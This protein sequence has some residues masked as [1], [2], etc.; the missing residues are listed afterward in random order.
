MNKTKINEE[1]IV[2][3]RTPQVKA[4]N[5]VQVGDIATDYAGEEY[6]VVVNGKAIDLLEKYDGT[7]AYAD[8]IEQGY[9]DPEDDVIVV[10]LDTRED[11]AMFT[12]DLDGAVV[13]E[14]L[15]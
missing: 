7:G 11:F 3:T 2:E 4:F 14:S 12:Y 15:K 10:S 13:Y 5:A 8:G 9:T 6:E 1:Q